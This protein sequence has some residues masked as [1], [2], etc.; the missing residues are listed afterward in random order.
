MSPQEWSTR[1]KRLAAAAGLDGAG[2]YV[3][4]L[5]G[6]SD[7]VFLLHLLARAGDRPALC[8]VHVDHGLRGAAAREDAAFCSRLCARLDV[9]FVLRTLELD[10]HAPGLE[11]RAREARYGA[12]FE[13]ARRIGARTVLTGHHADDALETVLLRWLRGTELGGLAALRADLRPATGAPRGAPAHPGARLSSPVSLRV[14]RPLIGMRREEVRR[15]LLSEGLAWR[16]DESNADLRF[17]RNRVRALLPRLSELGGA[18]GLDNLR[19]FGEAVER[20][21]ARLADAT[22]HL[23]W[24]IPTQAPASRPQ[25]QAH[26]L[27]R[28]PRGEL[29]QLP[30]ALRRRALW[31]LILEACGRGPRKALLTAVLDDLEAG[32]TGR[33]ALPAGHALLLRSHELICL[34]PS[35]APPRV[36]PP[37]QL[38]LDFGDTTTTSGSATFLLPV[39]GEILLDD[40][41][42]LRARLEDGAPDRPPPRGPCDVE[43]DPATAEETLSVRFACGGDRFHPLGAPGSKP[44]RRFLADAGVA[45]EERGRVPLVL[46]GGEIAWVAGVRPAER[47]R[48][49][50][51]SGVRLRLSLD[52]ALRACDD[53]DAPATAPA[54][55][56]GQVDLFADVAPLAP[57]R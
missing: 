17:E 13:E 6:G 20:L 22:A 56:A 37:R 41:R 45:R 2:P 48:L 4:A 47:R 36:A 12:L 19:A 38:R 40:G 7:S 24:R 27:G 31:R 39:P 35:A 42:R 34:P 53:E 8:A 46:A 30:A 43:L 52:H 32:R 29:M 23:A 15:W 28:L 5:S 33:H 9:P 50:G 44:L 11:A 25:S 16:E 49:R 57:A 26:L 18:Q 14:V 3:L 51:P 10:P 54:L 21:E 55:A 1:W